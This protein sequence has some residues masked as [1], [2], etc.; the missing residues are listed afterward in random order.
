MKPGG[1][2]LATC[3][4]RHSVWAWGDPSHTR[5]MQKEQLI[6]LNQEAYEAGVGK[7]AMSDFRDIYKAD[8]VPIMIDENNDKFA[9]IIQAVKP[10]RSYEKTTNNEA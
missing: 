1:R 2:L 7:T 8:F 9:F 10:P 4:S 3:P 6:F 5:I